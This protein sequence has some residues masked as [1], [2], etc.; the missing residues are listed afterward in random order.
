[1]KFSEREEEVFKKV[2]AL[3]QGDC[4]IH[5]CYHYIVTDDIRDDDVLA[6]CIEDGDTIL[7]NTEKVVRQITID[8]I[9]FHLGGEKP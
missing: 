1:M 9:I 3:C 4:F 8:E 6:V 2:G 5:E 7:I